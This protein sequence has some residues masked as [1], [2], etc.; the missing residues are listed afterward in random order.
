[1]GSSLPRLPVKPVP[2]GEKKHCTNLFP[3]IPVQIW[4]LQ[5]PNYSFSWGGIGEQRAPGTSG[6]G[7][8]TSGGVA[9]FP[10]ILRK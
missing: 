7:A 6:G 5:K 2:E 10:R 8:K 9:S 1:M 4:R 3:T